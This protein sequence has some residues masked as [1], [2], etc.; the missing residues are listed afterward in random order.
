MVIKKIRFFLFAGCLV[1]TVCFS[2]ANELS[3]LTQAFKT[4]K[5][6]EPSD[7]INTA[8]I[9]RTEGKFNNSQIQ[10]ALSQLRENVN[11]S[12]SSL[13]TSSAEY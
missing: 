3:T 5:V 9:A 12:T 6:L 10:M 2:R 11:L 8:A 1:S 4:K 13:L 7:S